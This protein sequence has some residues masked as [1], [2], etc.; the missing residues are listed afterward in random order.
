MS[1]S[2]Q[3]NLGDLLAQLVLQVEELL[4]AHLR[5]VRE[6]LT[7]D[8]KRMAAQSVGVV[9]GVVIVLLGL[10]FV[11]IALMEGLKGWLPPWAAALVVAV[12]LLGGGSLLA[13]FSLQ[14]LGKINP[15]DRTAVSTKETIL[16]LTR[17]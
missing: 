16:W 15:V 4:S 8:G 14:S 13:F 3:P 2:S 7:A 1:Q 11:G 10:V 12:G 9:T 6:E 17:R 5:L